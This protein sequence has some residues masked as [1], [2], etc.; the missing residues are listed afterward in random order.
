MRKTKLKLSGVDTYEEQLAWISYGVEMGWCGPAV[1][2]THDGLPTSEEE[3]VE[4]EEG[5]DPCISI[6]R[7]YNDDGQRQGVETNHSATLW[8]K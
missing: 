6:V 4:F 3:D 8:R 7:L 5:F 2:Y 1:C